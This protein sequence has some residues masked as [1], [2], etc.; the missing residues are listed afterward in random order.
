MGLDRAIDI[1]AGQRNTVLALL[2]RHLPHTTAWVYG[3]RAKWTARP[4]SDLDL[5]VF[6]TPEQHSRV[7]DLREELEESNLPFR[8]DL[9][10]WDAVPEQFRK[11][12]EA[13]HVALAT[14][15]DD[16]FDGRSSDMAVEWP[17]DRF[18]RLLTEP[19]RNGIYKR[20]EFH[21]RGAKIVNMGELFAHPRLRAVPM[22]RVELSESEADR[23]LITTG[24]L[25][26]AR[27][28]LV[29]EGAGKCCVVIDVDEPT[30]FESSIIRARPDSTKANYLY[31]YYFFNSALGLY[32]LDTIRRQVAVAGITGSDL[33]KLEIPVPFLPDQRAIAH[34]LGT[35]DDK[36]EL[37]RRM[38]ATLEA[39]AR[40]LFTSWFVKFDPVRAK[41][42]GRDT[43][44]P[45][46]I[47]DLFPDRLVESE[48]GEIPEGWEVQLLGEVVEIVKGRSYKSAEL[49]A[50]DTALVTLKSFE[51][52]GGYRRDGLKSFIGN[53]KEEQVI[54]P[55]E[56][57]IASTDVT[58]KA[59]VI[60]RTAIVRSARNYQTLVA[61]LDTLIV[62]PKDSRMTQAY[63]YFL[64]TTWSFVSHTHAHTT[65][66]TVL[67]LAKN[68]IPSFTFASPPRELV[69]CFN[70]VADQPLARV[71][72]LEEESET[73]AAL[74][75]TLLPKLVSGELR[76]N[77]GEP[78]LSAGERSPRRKSEELA[79]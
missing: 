70:V 19:V 38:N 68:A 72:V 41:M 1:T 46:H 71:Q 51:R 77:V 59:E 17:T 48:L 31:L 52:G 33:A 40:A 54:Q 75:D 3:S 21:G 63:L 8:V 36:I 11:R 58:Q 66:T 43:G 20:K 18:E 64:G 74:R 2:E 49:V 67:H 45:K 22:K 53:Y 42:E 35:L 34:I 12:I 61:S 55:G 14:A 44:L 9:F 50:S 56:V 15:D 60:G 79:G 76:M 62:R 16:P 57:V 29:A 78:T 26:F 47:A 65:G 6:A 69:R 73:L 4:Q 32:H 10:V 13:E 37:N 39:M 25:L 7:S 30:T 5:V 28:S 23:F 24:D 27:R